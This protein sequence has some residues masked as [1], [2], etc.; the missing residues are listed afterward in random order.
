M[1]ILF[2]VQ[3]GHTC[4]QVSLAQSISLTDLYFLNPEIDANCTNLDLDEA[5]FVK[6]VGSIT[7][8]Q[9]YTVTGYLLAFDWSDR[10]IL[11]ETMELN[12]P[13]ERRI[14]NCQSCN[15]VD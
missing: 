7:S 3:E 11:Y 8:Y 9:T 2:Q 13:N 15:R 14:K 12:S 1:W 6:A 10:S 5:Y 4:A